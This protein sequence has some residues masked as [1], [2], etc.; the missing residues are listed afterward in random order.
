MS[1]SNIINVKTDLALGVQKHRL[2]RLFAAS[3]KLAHTINVTVLQDGVAADLSGQSILAYF[4]RQ[5]ESTVTITGTITDNVATVTLPSSCYVMPGYFSLIIKAE[6]NV[7]TAIFWADG[8][9]TRS[10]T[11]SIVDPEHI[12]PSLSELLAL[13]DDISDI[14]KAAVTATN[15]ANTAAGQAS[16]QASAAEAAAG[17]AD[18]QAGVASAAAEDARTAASMV[19]QA[20]IPTFEIG[21]VTTLPA[22][23][24]ATASVDVSNP[25]TPVLN[26]GIPRGM[27]GDGSVVT[28]EGVSPDGNGNVSLP[29]AS[30]NQRG[31]IRVGSGLKM[32]GDTLS[33]DSYTLPTAS[34][35]TKGGV[36]VGAGL[37]M[38]G[39]A[40]GV[41]AYDELATGKTAVIDPTGEMHM[42]AINGDGVLGV[43][44]PLMAGADANNNGEQGMVP[45]PQAGDQAKFLRGDGTWQTVSGG[46]GS[47]SIDNIWPIGS[48]YMTVE[49]VNPGLL[50]GGTTWRRIEDR[51]LLAAGTT[52][53]AGSTGGEAEHTLTIAEMPSHRHAMDTG[54]KSVN[55]GS[56]YNRPM[57]LDTTTDEGEYR[58]SYQGGG[59]P[60]NNMPPYL[61][62]YIWQRV[63]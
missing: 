10:A 48:I 9:I 41:D 29:S 33:A 23:T 39:D 15:D 54:G 59:Q 6:G 11:D 60:H 3:D 44:L 35:T 21:T 61:A 45:A 7:S 37:K 14:K 16:A 1:A 17:R 28:V 31:L 53:A 55:K 46:G 63:A 32:D 25:L 13:I 18:Y 57:S 2:G 51:F 38:T 62:V 34:E 50:F 8:N 27:N 24:P 42:L 52:Y 43:C 36:Q 20:I 30:A 58:T 19:T 56:S 40:I 49:D 26:L 12:V 22:M 5:D 4:I 47:V